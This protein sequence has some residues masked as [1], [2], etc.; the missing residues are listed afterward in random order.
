MKHYLKNT[1]RENQVLMF[2]DKNLSRV[3]VYKGESCEVDIYD[4]L[5]DFTWS[6]N[7][8]FQNDY[9]ET[10]KNHFYNVF[11]RFTKKLNSVTKEL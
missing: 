2:N 5:S 6:L 9:I 3:E 10:T 1:E 8:A 11:V 7:Y 4:E